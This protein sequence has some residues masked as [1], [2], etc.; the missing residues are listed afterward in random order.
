[1]PIRQFTKNYHEVNKIM[2]EQNNPVNNEKNWMAISEKAV[3]RI[4]IY[5]CFVLIAGLIGSTEKNGVKS[6]FD[7]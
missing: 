3:L 5:Y 6:M 1:M 7:P 2:A 4:F